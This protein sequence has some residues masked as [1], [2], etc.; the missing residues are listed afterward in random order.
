MSGSGGKEAR[1]GGRLL[2]LLILSYQP[3]AWQVHLGY[4]FDETAWGQGY[5]SELVGGVVTALAPVA[6]VEGLGGVARDN[7][8]SARV[9][10]KNGFAVRD[11]LS[12]AET[13]IYARRA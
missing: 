10:V 6:P 4:L 2:G 13:E 7:P 11:D 12:D 1:E 8:A 5:A 3:E 9:L